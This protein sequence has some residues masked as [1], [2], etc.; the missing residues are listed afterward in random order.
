MVT[1]LPETLISPFEAICDGLRKLVDG[2]GEATAL[3]RLEDA[4]RP[5]VDQL[6]AAG[7]DGQANWLKEAV[8]YMV[9]AGELWAKHCAAPSPSS[10]M[11]YHDDLYQA[12]DGACLGICYELED[13]RPLPAGIEVIR[14]TPAEAA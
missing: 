1:P 11:A 4:A 8:R 13:R 6:V 9:S 2:Y 12:Y 3:K 5:M 7:C 14:L 10:Y